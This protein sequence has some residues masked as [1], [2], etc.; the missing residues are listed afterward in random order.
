MTEILNKEQPLCC[1]CEAPTEADLH[2]PALGEVCYACRDAA[3]MA[4]AALRAAGMH[5]LLSTPKNNTQSH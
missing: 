3:A 4:D 2:D 5:D 1:V